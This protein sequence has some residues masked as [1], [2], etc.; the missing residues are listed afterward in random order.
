MDRGKQQV[1]VKSMQT[2]SD[3]FIV[4]GGINGVGIA[5]DAA[6]RGLNVTLVEQADLAGA[7]SSASSKLIHGGL[8]YL[9]NYEFGL[10]R[11][12]L[13]ER[14]TLWKIA[15]HI[16]TPLRFVLPHHK[17]LRPAF[18]LRL[19][20][21]L[22][23]HI[24]GRKL[25]PPTKRINLA[26]HALGAPLADGFKLGFEYSDCWVDD[27]RLV[28]LN[29]IGAAEMG[30]EIH[31]RHSFIG[32]ERRD[33]QWHIRVKADGGETIEVTANMLVNAA[34]PWVDK[35]ISA[36]KL[37]RK[38]KGSVRLVKGSH[39]VVPKLYGH[40]QAYTF[41]NAD[42]RVIF[43]IPFQG[44]YTLVGTTDT[45]FD[46]DPRTAAADDGEIN[47]LCKVASEYFKAPLNPKDVV[48]SYS[49]VRPLYDDGAK[50]ASKATRDYV[51]EL[52]A[53][54]GLPPLLNIYGGKVTTYRRLAEEVL[55]KLEPY[56]DYN[57]GPWTSD[58]S[59][60][61][62]DLPNYDLSGEATPAKALEDFTLELEDKAPW[63]P[64]GLCKRLA[65]SYGTRV[66]DLLASAKSLDD[67]GEHFGAG[68][69]A[70][71]AWFL[72][73]TEWARTADDILWRRS[74]LGLHMTEAQ[75]ERVAEWTATEVAI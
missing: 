41:Q 6:G 25:L 40:S 28:V 29:A 61:G 11:E 31:T 63:L 38:N 68:L 51:L 44:D 13:M 75:R 19:G 5:R 48:W 72:R 52:K 50:N 14:E 18:I 33:G 12:S 16:I 3:I 60:P 69:Y 73:R 24:G 27:A 4:G 36:C 55:E 20:L 17:G 58:A 43:A 1:L 65:A 45:P 70:R 32:A 74:K 21:F 56:A 2:H 67:M 66:Y 42:G 71:E 26:K 49:G 34:G 64:S 62:G 37:T 39:I 47:Y 10:V 7:T 59:L 30:A 9:E 57:K 46:T 35:V 54:D 53:P 15:P 8:R 22:Y 23:D